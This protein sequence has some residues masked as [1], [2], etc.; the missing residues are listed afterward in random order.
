[1]KSLS[2]IILENRI[3]NIII[4]LLY[5]LFVIFIAIMFDKLFE[6]LVF[7]VTFS[8]IRNEFTKAIHGSDFTNSAHKSI[9]YCRLITT[10][11]QIISIIFLIKFDIS[12]YINLLLAFCLGILNFFC[13][14]YLEY[15]V[16]K[17][18]FYKGMAK[19]DIPE[20]LKGNEYKIIYM[21]YI[22]SYKLDKIAISLGYSVDNVKKI[23]SKILKR[24]S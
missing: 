11:I 22:E 18:L 21:Y 19:E 20:D 14:D 17:Q 23:K 12:K 4:S 16:K 13:K 6:F 8:F 3:K 15:K 1:M 7:L 24:Y 5:L 10:I 9:V 2:K